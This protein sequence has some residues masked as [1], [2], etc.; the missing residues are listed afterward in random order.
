[1]IKGKLYVGGWR[2]PRAAMSTRRSALEQAIN[3]L[4]GVILGL[5]G[6]IITVIA[7]IEDF[8]RGLLTEA[9]ISGQVQSI[10]LIVTAVLLILAALRLFGGIFGVLITIVLI[11]L[12]V[13][14][15]VP[16]MHVPGLATP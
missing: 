9:G 5:F 1:M 16:G 15:L 12:V 8:L 2:R 14:I 13:H 4:L 11:L 7:T 10:V 6:L 3:F